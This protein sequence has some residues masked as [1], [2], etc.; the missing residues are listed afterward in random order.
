MLGVNQI[1]SADEARLR[2]IHARMRIRS[3]ADCIRCAPTA[4]Q[5]A[6]ARSRKINLA[7]EDPVA[8]AAVEAAYDAIMMKQLA[9]RLKGQVTG[10]FGISK[11]LAFADK[12][13]S[14]A[15]M[16]RCCCDPW[17]F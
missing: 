7:K 1:A 3:N 14:S 8:I 11:E 16:R 4:P 9:L 17:S 13:V 6:S 12:H 2:V 5:L 10:G 15:R